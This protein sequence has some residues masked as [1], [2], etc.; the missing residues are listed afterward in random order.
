MNGAQIRGLALC[1]VGTLVLTTSARATFHLMQIE[2][3]IGGVNDDPSA[4]AIQLRMR[5]P[6]Q[7]IV[8]NA[9]L[10]AYDAAGLN[11]VIVMN[12]T[13]NVANSSAGDRVL[14]VSTNFANYSSPVM[15]ADF[16]M[17]RTIPTNY[18]AAGRLTFEQDTGAIYWSLSW[19]G[20]NYTGSNIG[21]ATHANDTDGN[22]GPAFPGDLPTSSTQSLIFTNIASALS[23]SKIVDYV[24]TA[25]SAVFTNNARARFVVVPAPVMLTFTNVGNDVRVPWTAAGGRSYVLEAV[26][27]DIANGFTNITGTITVPGVGPTTTNAL[28]VGGWTNSARFY[29]V[30]LLP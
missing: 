14:I 1:V 16:V 12:M 17:T 18:L 7:N 19:G 15:A 3:V 20:T 21:E 9:Q 26:S 2:Q 4:Q 6:F 10:V 28:D 29:R 24:I 8:S 5:S 30:R 11:P 25:G 22:F 13:N 23:R 27:G